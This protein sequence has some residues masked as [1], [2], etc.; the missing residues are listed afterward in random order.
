M[1]Q[2]DRTSPAGGQA[3]ARLTRSVIQAAFG[4]EERTM[5]SKSDGHSDP[6]HQLPWGARRWPVAVVV[7]VVA[8]LGLAACSSGATTGSS[9]T[10]LSSTPSSASNTID[11]QNFAFSPK[12]LTVH[13]GATVTV[14]NK[15]SVTHTLTAVSGPF[16]TMNVA[17]G[18][19]VHFVAPSK[20]GSY[21]YRCNI[22]QFM[23][24]TLV[25]S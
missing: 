20:P 3:D 13:P 4:S 10:A 23:T 7:V 9:T 5:L 11:I 8:L 17:G 19:V 14:D 15:D 21:P 2:S 18:S 1:A 24:G 16:N 6:S 22:H 12:T 25:V